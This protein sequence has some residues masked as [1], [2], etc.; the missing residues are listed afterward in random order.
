MD[1]DADSTQPYDPQQVVWLY[2][3]SL[4]SQNLS[5]NQDLFMRIKDKYNQ[6]CYK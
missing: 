4:S 6:E 5:K 1:S 2:W 3:A